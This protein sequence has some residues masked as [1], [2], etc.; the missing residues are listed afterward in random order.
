MKQAD[1]IPLYKSK[2][3]YIVTNYRTISLLVTLSKVLEKI[4]YSRTYNFLTNTNQMYQGQYGFRSGHSGQNAVSELI[5]TIQKNLEQNKM[6]IGVFIDL[7][8]A[9]DTLNHKILLAK[10]HKY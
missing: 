9:F 4:V 10:L 7:S 8:K 5:G 1:V 2:E 6:S 3:R